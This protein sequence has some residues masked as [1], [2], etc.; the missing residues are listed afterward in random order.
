MGM[1]IPMSRH[2]LHFICFVMALSA[3]VVNLAARAQAPSGEIR[4]TVTDPTG[5]LIPSAQIQLNG[6]HGNSRSVTGGHDGSFQIG[7]VAPGKYVMV[8]SAE[9]FAAATLENVEV[10]AGKTIQEKVTL[11]LPVDEQQVQVKEEAPGVSTDADA[12]ASAIVIKGKDLDAL[13]DDP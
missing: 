7:S 4:G 10:A 3:L 12:N 9:G 13:S 2:V 8:I 11:Q 6:S 1:E 5:A